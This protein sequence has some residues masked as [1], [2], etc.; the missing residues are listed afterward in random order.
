MPSGAGGSGIKDGGIATGGR[1]NQRNGGDGIC[2]IQYYCWD[3]EF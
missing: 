2:I 1:Y 3:V